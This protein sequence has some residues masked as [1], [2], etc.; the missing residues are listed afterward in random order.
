M[1]HL[2]T[3]I[4]VTFNHSVNITTFSHLVT[5]YITTFNHLVTTCITTFS[6]LVT[7][8][9][10]TFSHLVTTYTTTFSHLVTMY[11]TT[12][13]HLVTTCITTFNHLVT[14]CITTFSHLVTMYTTTFSHLVTTYTTTFSHL[15]ITY[16]TT[17]NHLVNTVIS[18]LSSIYM[19]VPPVGGLSWY[20]WGRKKAIVNV[21]AQVGPDPGSM[22]VETGVVI[23][24]RISEG[25]TKVWAGMFRGRKIIL[26]QLYIMCGRNI[27]FDTVVYLLKARLWIY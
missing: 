12:F 26:M 3:W 17:F 9:T 25:K 16:I 5:T 11:I 13:S 27:D 4:L 2:N 23:S 15:V 18:G 10:T 14:M 1:S 22:Y 8:Y 19:S 24:I 21:D 7:M 20:S 6:H